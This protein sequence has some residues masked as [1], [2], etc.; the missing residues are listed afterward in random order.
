MK[1]E[2]FLIKVEGDDSRHLPDG[3]VA[4]TFDNLGGV[5]NLGPG[6]THG[7]TKDTVWTQEELQ[8]AEAREFAETR[9]TVA[10]LVT[11]PLTENQRTALESLVYNI[12]AG[13]FARTTVLRR[14]NS[15]EFSAVPDAFRMWNKAG[16]SI[17]K[18]LIN[19]RE[20]EIKLWLHPDDVPPTLDMK[21]PINVPRATIANQEDKTMAATTVSTAGVNVS[22]T[23]LLTNV[24]GTLFSL[25]VPAVTALSGGS[26]YITAVTGI[27]GILSAGA[28][29]WNMISHNSAASQ[30][31]TAVIDTLREQLLEAAGNKG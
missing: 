27:L 18:G 31:T 17:C 7:V 30:N 21:T 8:A 6:L 19:R 28:H 25:A 29:I 12:G 22:T 4:A 1:L 24:T 3:R 13:G 23:T 2:D 26:T 14:V 11:V 16:G 15:R 10:K 9:A 5:Y 20:A